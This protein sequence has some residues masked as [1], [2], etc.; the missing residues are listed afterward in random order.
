MTN[1]PKVKVVILRNELKDDHNLWI[2]A[3]E[4]YRDK[5]E[6]I[7]VDLI[8]NNWLKEIR[9]TPCDI[10]LAKPGGLTAPFKQL[11]DERVYILGN[12]LCYKIYPSPLE[13]FIYENKRFFSYWLNANNIPHPATYI[14]YEQSEALEHLNNTLYPFVA[15]VNIGASG[16]GVKIIKNKNEAQKYI[17]HTFSGKGSPQRTGP[18]LEKGGILQRGLHYVFHPLDITKKLDIYQTRSSNLQRGF[19]IFQDYIPNDYEWR[20]VRIGDSFFAHKKLKVGDKASGLLIKQY[21]NP[22]LEILDFVKEITDKHKFYSQAV[23]I[24]E[25]EGGYL[26]NEMQCIFGQ[27]DPYQMLVDGVPGRYRYLNNKWEFEEGDF[28]TN[29]CYNLRVQHILSSFR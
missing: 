7:V 3:C 4:E 20:V 15:K 13:I 28:T 16:S 23:D 12:V 21:D 22:P 6:Y 9:K 17:N 26:I 18:N 11:Y 29:Q 2:K 1:K 14:Y 19:V 27:S 25:F 24:F 10:L 8:C 5:L